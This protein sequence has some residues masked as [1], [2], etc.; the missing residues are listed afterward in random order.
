MQLSGISLIQKLQF[1]VVA[2]SI[3]KGKADDVISFAFPK[4]KMGGFD[5]QD[6]ELGI[7]ASSSFT[8]LLN[9]VG[10]NGLNLTTVQIQDTAA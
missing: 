3:G 8:A 5:K 4:I 1:L 7:I 2:L 10:T 6:G 9:D